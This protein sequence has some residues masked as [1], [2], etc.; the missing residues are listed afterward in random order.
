MTLSKTTALRHLLMREDLGFLMEAHSGL[1]A[2]VA[3][4]AGFEGLWG[5]GLSISASMGVRDNNEMSWTQV[6]DLVEFIGDA[7]KIPILLDGDTG[8]GNFNNMRRLVRKLETRD[9]AGV[10]I[11]DKLFPKTNSFIGENQP[12]ADMDEFCGKI[13][14]G[15]DAQLDDDFSIVARVEA[16][17]A[18]WG[19]SEALK[20]A[21]AYRRAGADAIL[22]HSKHSKP[23][24]ILAFMKEWGNRGPVVIVPTTYYSTPTEA[25][26]EAGVSVVIWA[27]HLMRSSLTAMHQTAQ[28]IREEESLINVEDRIVTVKEVF[29]IQGASELEEAERRYLPV[30]EEA[31]HALILAAGRGKELGVLTE[32]RPKAMVEI[33]G[34]P[35][36]ER[37]VDTL[38]SIGI[39]EIT[40]VRGYRKE[41]IDL[42]NLRYVDNDE[43]AGTQEAFSL[44][45][46]LERLSGSVLVAYG[47]VLFQ[48]F[49][50]MDLFESSSDFC[51]AVDPA[52]K[53]GPNE[54]R[55][56]DLV[57]CDRPFHWSEF[58]QRSRLIK[59]STDL[60]ADTVHGEWIGLLKMSAS[61]VEQ[62]RA[63]GAS[64]TDAAQLR[65]MRMADVFDLLIAN[66]RQV[67]VVYIRGHWL[68][69]DD[70]RDV[71][72]AS[73]FGGAGQ[74]G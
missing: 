25:F 19:L 24:E 8:Y 10:C 48:K 49:I 28:Q 26:R 18:G 46:G 61:G 21:E 69:V 44:F 36:L 66:G 13:K 62:L 56:R 52:W 55:Y 39:K 68:D 45:T 3:E 50:P 1:S 29:R 43:H 60:S 6:I 22:I 37:T 17:I 16:L 38:N 34:K 2:R 20:R 32:D 74:Y 53:G 63:L 70:M 41:A 7:V 51:I 15:K 5:S 23:D 11:E 33:A 31:P 27:N 65:S 9:I 73:N 64:V 57:T 12:L 14:A 67:E 72:A 47:D 4:E 42:P 58:D 30:R 59:M 40:V 35:L 71:V 54:D